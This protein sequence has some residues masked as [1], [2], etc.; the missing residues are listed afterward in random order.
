MSNVMSFLPKEKTHKLHCVDTE[1]FRYSS[2]EAQENFFSSIRARSHNNGE[3]IYLQDDIAL[4]LYVVLEGYIRLSYMME[5]GSAILYSIIPAGKIFGE[6]GI[7]DGG[8]QCDTATSIGVSSIGSVD[9][10]R[11]RDL[12]E[13][14]RDLHKDIAMLVAQ[15]FRSYVELTRIMSLRRLQSRVSLALLRLADSLNQTISYEGKRYLAVGSVVTQS[16]LAIMARGSRGNINRTLK[17]W[18][19]S[20]LII[21]KNRTILIKERPALEALVLEDGL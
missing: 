8:Q 3:V 6:L 16:D 13:R 18:E 4:N 10:K 15:R 20:G 11:F 19:R 2:P 7:F 17:S 12:C 9:G 5:D 1:F 14:Y 21:V